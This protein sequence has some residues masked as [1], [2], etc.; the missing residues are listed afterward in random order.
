MSIEPTPRR[1]LAGQLLTPTIAIALLFT[2]LISGFLIYWP[3]SMDRA[4]REREEALVTNGFTAR[5]AELEALISPNA[6][7]DDAV[8]NLAV[9]YAPDWARDNVGVYF[10]DTSG[11]QFAYVLDAE[12][13]PIYGRQDGGDVEPSR[14]SVL[15]PAS[16][17]IVGQVRAAEV[18]RGPI[19][20]TAGGGVAI[21]QPIQSSTIALISGQ[22]TVLT[23]TLVQ[24]DFGKAL[25]PRDKAPII[26]TGRALSGDFLGR[27]SSRYLLTDAR[28]V[29]V[30]TPPERDLASANL[31]V[32]GDR[33]VMRMQWR[34][35]TP[36]H[37][38]LSRLLPPLGILALMVALAVA[39]VA[40]R[41]RHRVL[42]PL[43]EATAALTDLAEGRPVATPPGLD[44]TDEI[45]ELCRA[46]ARLHLAGQEADE[47]RQEAQRERE[48]R[49]AGS[50]AAQA[51]R[52]GLLDQQHH[53]VASLAEGLERLSRGEL[54]YRIAAPFAGDYER[55]RT[56]FNAAMDELGQ[57]IQV[58]GASAQQI[59]SGVD[60]VRHD[61]EDL[62]RRT[63]RQADSLDE[64]A[65]ALDQITTALR[66]A[67]EGAS[68]AQQV[69]SVANGDAEQGGVVV[70]RTVEAMARIEESSKQI[71][72]I[73]GVIDEIAFQ[74]NLLAL[75]AGVEAAR[76]GEAGR[77]FA[78]VA[79][80]VRA[81]AQRSADA[82]KEIKGLIAESGGHVTEGVTLAGQSGE[83]L[84]RIVT[85]VGDINR[86]VG[87]ILASTRQQ[88][89][90]LQGVNAAV[91]EMDQV[92]RQNATMVQQTLAT[93]EALAT[94]AAL[95]NAKVGR[96]T[97]DRA[98]P[99]P[100]R[101]L[102]D[103][104]ARRFTRVG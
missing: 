29:P 72:Q 101:D 70:Q 71:S 14:F 103:R 80:E 96:F 63:D 18:A 83:A 62:S 68:Q 47:L 10:T 95:M 40:R 9:A 75:N 78:V 51:Q 11:F 91:S 43:R 31:R 92:T 28:V 33:A 65:R 93:T 15:D 50:Q 88:A 74:T 54:G 53:V 73:I 39:L 19:G 32:G 27:F 36:G 12:G 77:G 23:A 94:E 3:S 20:A 24:P 82:A 46:F 8:Q 7:W 42:A 57:T 17:A 99:G 79:S 102:Q 58:I 34:P 97:L 21:S 13:R 67:A 64:S 45:G 76:A 48:A 85:R 4:S 98:G 1:S 86:V 2:V 25:P 59:H 35:K 37:D 69:V 87:E 84:E 30:E 55:L 16:R 66:Q 61:A 56:I 104:L 89:G 22:P 100:V 41:L 49:D 60:R 6:N 81:L 26:V 38:L 90:A 52:Q 44:R 5:V